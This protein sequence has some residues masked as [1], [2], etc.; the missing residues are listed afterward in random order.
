MRA[1]RYERYGG[2]ERLRLVEVPT[3]EPRTGQLLVRVRA[4]SVNSWDWDLLRGRPLLARLGPEPFEPGFDA[5]YLWQALRPR[6]AAIK[7]AL[8]DNGVVVGVGNIYASEALFRA[9]IRPATPAR[10]VSR[11]RLARLVEAVREVLR[12]AIESGGSTLRDYVD[13]G[14]RPGR[15]RDQ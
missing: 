7:L 3:P 2:P 13:A 4:A 10:K 8:M 14:G 11:A 12:A 1:V 5:H 15:R 6:S 9:G